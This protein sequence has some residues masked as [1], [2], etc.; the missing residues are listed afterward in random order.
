M[1]SD[2]LQDFSLESLWSSAKEGVTEATNKLVGEAEA[3]TKKAASDVVDKGSQAVT[4]EIN[5]LIGVGGNNTP[6]PPL[7]V[8]ATEKPVTTA[9]RLSGLTQ[10]AIP[11]GVGV[12][13]YFWQKSILWGA[14]AAVATLLI[15]R[16]M[17]KGGN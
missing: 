4:S 11:A 6:Q 7:P 13:V 14:G 17:R 2:T 1:Y 16:M 12:G 15:T 10:Y 5:K 8:Q 3:A 9:S